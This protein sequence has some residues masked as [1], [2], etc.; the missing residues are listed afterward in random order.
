MIASHSRGFSR[1]NASLLIATLLLPGCA[2]FRAPDRDFSESPYVPDEFSMTAVDSRRDSVESTPAYGPWWERFASPELNRLVSTSLSDNLSIAEAYAR[3]TQ[4]RARAVQSGAARWPD[5]SLEAD[6][7]RTEQRRPGTDGSFA[8][9]ETKSYGAG[10]ASSF[11]LDLWGRTRALH[12]SGRAERSAA[13]EDLQATAITISAEVTLRWLALL[14]QRQR[15]D[16]LHQQLDA[17]ER[18]LELTELRFAKSQAT[19]LDVLR[20]RDAVS[21]VRAQL[22]TETAREATLLHEIAVL[23]GKPPRTEL[24]ITSRSLPEPPPVPDA[25]LPIELLTRRP[26]LQSAAYRLQSA[27]WNVSA[28]RADRLPSIRLSASGGLRAGT[29]ADLLEGTITQLSGN[30]VAPL[31]EGGARKAEVARTRGAVEEQLAAYH[32]L[33]LQAVQEVEGALIQ[34]Q[35]QSERIREVERQLENANLTYAESLSRYRKGIIDFLP[36]LDAQ[37]KA[38]ETE[39]SLVTAKYE[40]LAFRVQLHRAL[41]GDWVDEFEFRPSPGDRLQ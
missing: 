30:L 29:I 34:E 35:S 7:S 5:L 19:A 22:P 36:V 14:A 6:G 15:L 23:L 31:F 20:Q 1:R 10:L 40:R 3:L 4:A 32:G 26:D 21:A 18:L 28:A 33:V 39:R 2:V 9:V 27:D 25:G 13:R 38:Q 37:E 17:N 16:L 8:T 41:G 12:E 11:E 24:G